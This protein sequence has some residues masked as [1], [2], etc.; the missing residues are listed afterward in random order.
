MTLVILILGFLFGAILQYARLNKYDVISRLA[1]LEDLAV[2]KAIV[3]AIGV[4]AIVL[5][6]EIA[7]GLAH[8]HVK[9][10]VLGGVILGGIIF[11]SGMAILGYCPGT[12]AISLGEGA[13]DALVGIIGGLLGGLVFTLTFP[14]IQGLLGPN[15]GKV[16]LSGLVGGPSVLFFIL[17]FVIAIAFIYFAFWLDQKEG[18]PDR[19]WLY[20]G[21]A[22]ALLNAFV[23][24]GSVANRPI[25][26]STTYPYLADYLFG[27]TDNAYFAKIRTPGHWELIFLG[28]AFL[29][30]LIVSLIKKEF[31]LQLIFSNWEHYKGKTPWHRI[32]WAFVG[33]FILI[34]GARMAGGCTSGH[35]LSGGMQLAVSSLTFA[36]FVFIG[37]LGTGKLFYKNAPKQ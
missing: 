7:A 13:L 34:F 20:S 8:Y 23:F 36:V 4:G 24:L 31:K 12:L 28:G 10:F 15:L 32:L 2:A 26:A 27:F 19:K 9:P 21:L 37:L 18:K 35:I 30:G 33:G 16:S 14:G 11:G 1:T 22:L 25:G 17:L 3:L 6:I 29:A 5:N